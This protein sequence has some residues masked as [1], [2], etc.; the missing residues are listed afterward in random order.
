MKDKG[1][2]ALL[3]FFLGIFGI[4]RFYLRQ[5][6]LGIL[7]FFL[8]VTTI[9]FFL[10]IIDFIVFLSM[11]RR[12]FDEKYNKDYLSDDRYSS[13]DRPDYRR[14]ERSDRF[15]REQVRNYRDP[16]YRREERRRPPEPAPR[17]A[18]KPKKKSNPYRR[19]GIEK[20]KDYD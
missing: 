20:Y 10:S 13:Y 8:S 19:S 14:R 17:P 4:H 12:T 7:Y 2:A 11:D 3:A 5:T 16:E 15:R 9:S 1:A 18:P 6:G